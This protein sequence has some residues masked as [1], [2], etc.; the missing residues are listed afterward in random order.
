MESTP[1]SPIPQ[2][3]PQ[4]KK[5]N[6]FFFIFW[7]ISTIAWLTV[8]IRRLVVTQDIVGALIF[9]AVAITSAILAF[10]FYKG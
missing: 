1:Q 3:K 6:K 2:T 8:S 5:T 9:L 4:T 10:K 7:S